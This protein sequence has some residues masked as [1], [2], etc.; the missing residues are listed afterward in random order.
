[1]REIILRDTISRLYIDDFDEPT[2]KDRCLLYDSDK[3]YL[4][5][6][7]LEDNTKEDYETYIELLKRHYDGFDVFDWLCDNTSYDYGK[8]PQEIMRTYIEDLVNGYDLEQVK[9]EIKDIL[10]DIE[11]LT[12]EEF[13]QTYDINRIGKYYFRGNW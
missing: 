5:Y 4:D 11:F 12:D 2:E 3:R 1:M 8:T 10:F 13:C 6:F 7:S 9:E